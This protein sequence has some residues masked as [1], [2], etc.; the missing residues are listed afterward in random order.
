MARH[1]FQLSEY[2]C[3]GSYYTEWIFTAI[4]FSRSCNGTNYSHKK[5]SQIKKIKIFF[6]T[7]YAQSMDRDNLRI[8]LCKPLIQALHRQSPNWSSLAHALL[9]AWHVYANWTMAHCEA[10]EQPMKIPFLFTK[11]VKGKL[12]IWESICIKSMYRNAPFTDHARLHSAIQSGESKVELAMYCRAIFN[13]VNYVVYFSCYPCFVQCFG[14]NPR[15]VQSRLSKDWSFI[16]TLHP[17]LDAIWV[18]HS[19]SED[20]L[21]KAQIWGLC[22]TILRLPRSTLCTWYIH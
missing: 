11:K 10:L 21:C 5:N 18:L 2:T 19:Q 13:G 1:L 14:C 22:K 16:H 20:C 17:L 9:P 7:C 8:V 12:L 15:N 4:M 3:A 6:C